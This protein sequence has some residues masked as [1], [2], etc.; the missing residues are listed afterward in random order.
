MLPTLEEGDVCEE[1]A[2]LLT[3]GSGTGTG[4]PG[5][6]P[7]LASRLSSRLSSRLARVASRSTADGDALAADDSPPSVLVSKASTGHARLAAL[8]LRKKLS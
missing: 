2:A 7:Q 6:G 3:A 4:S 8:T 5:L 1:P